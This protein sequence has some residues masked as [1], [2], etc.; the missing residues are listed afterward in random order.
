MPVLLLL[1]RPHQGLQQEGMLVSDPSSGKAKE[2]IRFRRNVYS[3]L[4]EENGRKQLSR[5][6][7]MER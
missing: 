6:H 2:R 3:I 1:G 4:R 7:D 5:K